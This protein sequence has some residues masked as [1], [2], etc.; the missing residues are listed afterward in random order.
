MAERQSGIWEQANNC[1]KNNGEDTYGSST[2]D[3]PVGPTLLWLHFHVSEFCG[4]NLLPKG[5]EHLKNTFSPDVFIRLS[6]CHPFPPRFC[7]SD[8]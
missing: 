1:Q 7:K 5:M 6:V 2:G 4:E 3:K 8:F